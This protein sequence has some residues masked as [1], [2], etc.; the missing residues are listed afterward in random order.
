MANLFIFFL[1][2]LILTFLIFLIVYFINS[3]QDIIDYEKKSAY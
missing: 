2:S 1:V 3:N